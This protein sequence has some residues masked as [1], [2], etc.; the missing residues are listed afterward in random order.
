MIVCNGRS[1]TQ[2]TTGIQRY[3]REI[4]RRIPGMAVIR[5][6]HAVGQ[7]RGILWEQTVLPLR[8]RGRPI[9]SPSNTAPLVTRGPLVVTLHDLAMLEGPDAD[10][11]PGWTRFYRWFIPRMLKRVDAVLTVSE[12]S[13]RAIIERFGVPPDRILATPLGVD[14]DRFRPAEPEALDRFLT[15]HALT[16]GY[17][18][19]VGSGS[20]RKNLRGLIDAWTTIA[21]RLDASIELVIA[22]DAAAYGRAFDGSE[23]PPL[24]PRARLVGRVDDA[25]LPLL[26][27][28]AGVF[29]F[30]SFAEGFG[31]PPLEAMACGTPTVVS[32]VTSLP[33]VVGEAAL[34]VDPHDTS[35][36]GDALVRL[37]TDHQ[38]HA[39]LRAVGIE[40][41]RRFDWDETAGL[42]HA[43]LK[44]FA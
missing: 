1:L 20:A 11:A 31:L 33:E 6:E 2:S 29:A 12:Y 16:P 8:A 13:R 40:R 37:L 3:T 42:T 36:L 15:A 39:R 44:R 9:W 28:G 43:F 35:A 23:I 25:D 7:A 38:L 41:A 4:T 24:P 21:P 17:V 19:S 22:G 10:A 14:H 32:D 30:P 18:L 27:A 5:P 34:L 26:M